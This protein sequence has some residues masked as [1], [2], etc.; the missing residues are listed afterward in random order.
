M[1][2]SPFRPEEYRL[3]SS[4]VGEVYPRAD[5][6]EARIFLAWGFRTGLGE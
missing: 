6:Q 3:A 5:L 4:Y 1:I 2:Q